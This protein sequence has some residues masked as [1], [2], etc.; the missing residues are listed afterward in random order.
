MPAL[1]FEPDAETWATAWPALRKGIRTAFA[2]VADVQVQVHKLAH[3]SG[4]PAG[5]PSSH[6]LRAARILAGLGV[7]ELSAECEMAPGSIVNIE[8]RTTGRGPGAQAHARHDA[9]G[10]RAARGG[11][12][13][14]RVGAAR[15]R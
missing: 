10:A 1:G 5:C 14:V 6:Q 7:R 2:D 8:N 9:D 3:D 13:D 4:W 11:V 12:R 15:G